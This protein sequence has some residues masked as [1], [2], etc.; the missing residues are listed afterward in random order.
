M[1]EDQTPQE[2]S[3][4][5]IVL[6]ES[7]RT[8][9]KAWIAAGGCFVFVCAAVFVGALIFFGPRAVQS[10][11]P[12]GVDIAGEQPREIT[13]NNTMGDPNAPIH[14]I[15]YGDF[16]CPFCLRFWNE[17]EPQLI[18]EY[19]NTGKVYFEFRAFPILGPESVWAAEGAYCAG[20]QG[21][22]WEYHDTLFTNWTGENVGDFKHEKLIQYAETL[23]LDVDEFESCLSGEKYA[24]RVAQDK[25][26]GEAAG[27]HATPTFIING[28]VLEG[29]QPF[30]ILQ[31]I[32]EEMLNGDF[33]TMNG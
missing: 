24:S 18:E 2:L 23:G 1:I 16:Q 14:I 21:K 7:P 33:N 13:E 3:N 29:A 31:H 30:D 28:N 8:K 12:S 32:I 22:F 11:F 17:T 19:V 25:A 20:D 15:E 9:W 4:E 26:N 10:L 6:E 27:V 5:P